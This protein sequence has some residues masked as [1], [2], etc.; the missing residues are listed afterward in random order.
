MNCPICS[1]TILLKGAN[2]E[3]EHLKLTI[4]NQ[5]RKIEQLEYDKNHGIK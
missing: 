2:Q 5:E 4:Y 1:S 3:I